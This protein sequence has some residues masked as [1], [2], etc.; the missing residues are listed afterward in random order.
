MGYEVYR[1]ELQAAHD[2]VLRVELVRRNY[3]S[4][5][6]VVEAILQH[7]GLK[8]T[9]TELMS[10][11]S[12][13]VETH[14]VSLLD[15]AA[16]AVPLLSKSYKVAVLSSLP[17]FLIRPVLEPVKHHVGAI[18]TPYEAKATLPNPKVFRVAAQALGLKARDVTVVSAECDDG[19]AVPKSLG[20][21]TA[22]VRHESVAGCAYATISVPTLEDLEAA[23]KQPGKLGEPAT[24]QVPAVPASGA[25]GK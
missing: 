10:L 4:A 18:V 6:K 1:P 2:F 22:F 17:A 23:L 8:P 3:D 19:L 15:D 9:R 11:A 24:P 13:F 25:V 21:R 20:F 12:L 5:E 14:R 7:L 16:R